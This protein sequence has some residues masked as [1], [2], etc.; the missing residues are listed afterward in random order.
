MGAI[1]GLAV[2]LWL[3]AETAD[4]APVS[5]LVSRPVGWVLL[6]AATVV[7]LL[8]VPAGSDSTTVPTMHH[9]TTPSVGPASVSGPGE[10]AFPLVPD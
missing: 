5:R 9:P 10:P 2:G 8:A 3:V 6:V 7:L 1:V 4:R